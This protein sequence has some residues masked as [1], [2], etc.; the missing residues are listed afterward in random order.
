MESINNMVNN[1][2]T[3][4]IRTSYHEYNAQHRNLPAVPRHNLELYKKS[5]ST[6]EQGLLISLSR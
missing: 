4:E 6:Q 1:T 5:L 3:L 2:I